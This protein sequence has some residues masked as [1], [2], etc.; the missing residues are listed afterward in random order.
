MATNNLEKRIKN[1]EKIIELLGEIESLA[2]T[3]ETEESPPLIELS[4]LGAVSAEVENKIKN[5]LYEKRRT[6]KAK[7]SA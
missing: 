2:K 6:E 1:L 5:L 7:G 4:N 3:K